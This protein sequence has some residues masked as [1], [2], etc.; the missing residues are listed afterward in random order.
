MNVMFAQ[1]R[2]FAGLFARGR[3]VS[4][5]LYLTL[6]RLS[7]NTTEALRDIRSAIRASPRLQDEV[8]ALFEDPN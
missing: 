2:S 4:V 5:P 1:F 8:I 6:L 7:D 3:T